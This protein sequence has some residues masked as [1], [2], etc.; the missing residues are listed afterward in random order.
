MSVLLWLLV[1][2]AAFLAC[3]WGGATLARHHGDGHEVL[4]VLVIGLSAIGAMAWADVGEGLTLALIAAGVVCAVG[5]FDG[6]RHA[7]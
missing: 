6:Y 4:G 3:R 2:V 1:L 7:E 5:L